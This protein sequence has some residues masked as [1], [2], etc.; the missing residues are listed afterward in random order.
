MPCG[1]CDRSNPTG[2]T[3]AEQDRINAKHKITSHYMML[4]INS[5]SVVFQASYLIIDFYLHGK[6][7]QAVSAIT[8]LR[9]YPSVRLDLL[10]FAFSNATGQMFIFAMI[11]EY[12]SLWNVTVTITRKLWSILLS[13]VIYGHVIVWWQWLGC[14]SVFLGLALSIWYKAQSG[15]KEKGH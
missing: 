9:D 13:I 3:N 2:F 14:F 1:L 5:W 15:K 10:G 6:A 12:G 4:M 11:R 7:S 8:F